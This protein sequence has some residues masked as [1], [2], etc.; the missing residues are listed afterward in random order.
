MKTIFRGGK[1][2]RPGSFAK[3]EDCF[4]PGEILVD[5]EKIAAVGATLRESF[6]RE[7]DLKGKCILPGLIDVHAHFRDPG[8]AHKEG[9]GNGSRA[10]A[11]GGVTCVF[12]IQNNEPLSIDAA[13]IRERHEI[14]SRGLV[15]FGCYGNLLPASVA[16][17]REMAPLV[18]AFKLFMG[19]STGLDGIPDR[20]L[21]R[22]LFAAAADAG[23][24]IVAHCEDES[25]LRREAGKAQNAS[26]ADHHRLRPR[27]AEI[28]S[29]SLAVELCRETGASLH[30]FHLSTS[31]GAARVR[32]A[33]RAGLPVTASVSHHNLRLTCEDTKRL[34]NALRVNPPIQTAEDRRELCRAVADGTIDAIATDHAPHPPEEKARPYAQAPSGIP[35]IEFFLPL[36]VTPW[37]E[38]IPFGR[39][40]DAATAAPAC[41]FGMQGKGALDPGNDADLVLAD[42]DAWREISD[43]EVVSRAGYTPYRG[44][45]VRGLVLGSWVR[46]RPVFE[47]ES[48]AGRFANGPW[49]KAA[50]LLPPSPIRK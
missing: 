7:I 50:R 27:E 1:I 16:K 25:I 10:A 31:E 6:D 19:G 37:E 22:D 12:E 24:P 9:W 38:P 20:K 3:L 47:R 41:L 32:E 18:P 15:D 36:L 42:L 23:R 34:G 17:L 21:L 33:K 45:R 43:A 29:V 26:A 4:I 48:G 30:A 39:A 46:G 13:R 40:L 35:S 14:A 2:F 5:G 44:M 11:R 28:E 49:G 8:L